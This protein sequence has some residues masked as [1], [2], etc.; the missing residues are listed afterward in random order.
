MMNQKGVIF[1]D[2][3]LELEMKNQEENF[4]SGILCL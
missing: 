2:Y 3:S 1:K 4:I